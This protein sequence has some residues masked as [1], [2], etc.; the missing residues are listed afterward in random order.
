MSTRPRPSRNSTKSTTSHDTFPRPHRLSTPPHSPDARISPYFKPPATACKI[1][2]SYD[3]PHLADA[4]E[5]C[6]FYSAG[7]F[8]PRFSKYVLHYHMLYYVMPSLSMF[9]LIVSGCLVGVFSLTH[10]LHFVPCAHIN[11]IYK[12]LYTK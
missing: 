9:F 1:Y 7:I 11:F 12:L 4:A 6:A 5:S 3:S 2:R 10:S 8:A